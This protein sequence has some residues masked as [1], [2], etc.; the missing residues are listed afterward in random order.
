MAIR[1]SDQVFVS[2]IKPRLSLVQ[3]WIDTNYRRSINRA[4]ERPFLPRRTRPLLELPS[5][6]VPG[7]LRA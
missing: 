4:Q 6:L 1:F 3:F 7:S 2:K 5:H